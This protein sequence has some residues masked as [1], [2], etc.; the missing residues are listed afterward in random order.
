MKL[1]DRFKG[2]IT[3]AISFAVIYVGFYVFVGPVLS[4]L[5]KHIIGASFGSK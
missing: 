1:D 5:S 2:A 3:V 4:Y